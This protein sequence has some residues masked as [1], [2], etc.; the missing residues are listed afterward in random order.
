MK[1][2]LWLQLVVSTGYSSHII[3]LAVQTKVLTLQIYK[4]YLDLLFTVIVP[5]MGLIIFNLKIF[6]AIRKNRN[7]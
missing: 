4:Q 3:V 7:R 2:I 5:L 6:L 1:T